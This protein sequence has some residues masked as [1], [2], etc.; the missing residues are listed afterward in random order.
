[1]R[2]R[3]FGKL[4]GKTRTEPRLGERAIFAAVEQT[5][6][7]EVSIA[8][9]RWHQHTDFEYLR[10]MIDSAKQRARITEQ[11]SDADATARAWL[12]ALI[13]QAP[14]AAQA[15]AQMDKHRHGFHDRSNRVMELIDFNDAYVST[16]LAMPP[17]HLHDF[18]DETKQLI[19]W[20]CK[21]VGAWTFTDEQFEAIAHGLSREI[22][23]YNAVQAAGFGAQMT[24]R[25]EDAF[26]IDIHIT[27]RTTGR[28]INVDIKTTSAFHYRLIEL[29][30][31]GRIEDADMD[32]AETRGYAAVYNG[33]GD[34][35]IRVV[36]WRIDHDTLGD[37]QDF[38]FATTEQLIR[39]LSEIFTAYGE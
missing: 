19:D 12:R 2:W 31:E 27:D 6:R 36:L 29:L 37:I 25:S 4:G 24:T 16:V 22:A 23:V 21:R 14:H 5:L 13:L 20:F 28:R 3:R 7:D 33:H 15:Q 1:M 38:A 26:G 32:L 39:E 17:D 8:R 34:E 35:K 10:P 30:S 9:K 18:N 11:G